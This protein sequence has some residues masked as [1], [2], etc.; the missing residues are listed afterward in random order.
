MENK[1]IEKNKTGKKTFQEA[2]L[3]QLTLKGLLS[4][5][6]SYIG[7][8]ANNTKTI[9]GNILLSIKVLIA[10]IEGLILTI[11]FQIKTR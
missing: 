2:E 9:N 11:I 5:V 4:I 10:I 1:Q 7:L 8:N 3:D 6:M